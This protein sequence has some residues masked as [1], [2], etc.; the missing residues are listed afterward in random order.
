[1]VA[2]IPE[3]SVLLRIH[4][5]WSSIFILPKQVLKVKG[6][7]AI[8]RNFP[9]DGKVNTTKT[10]WPGNWCADQR[11]KAFLDHKICEIE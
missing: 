9:W 3:N 2:V 4:S 10:L 7:T 1:M 6:I 5:Y 11:A 8:C